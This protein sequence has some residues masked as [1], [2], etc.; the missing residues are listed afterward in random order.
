MLNE[1]NRQ[2]IEIDKEI[3]KEIS[4]QM[5]GFTVNDIRCLVR[6]YSIAYQ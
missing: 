3:L 1:F 6:E 2:N 4:Y 5:S